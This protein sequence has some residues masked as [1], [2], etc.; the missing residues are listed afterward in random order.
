MEDDPEKNARVEPEETPEDIDRDLVVPVEE[1]PEEYEEEVEA[2]N[3]TEA[4]AD[5]D[6]LADVPAERVDMKPIP[7]P[8][9]STKVSRPPDRYGNNVMM[10]SVSRPIN[11]KLDVVSALMTSGALNSMDSETVS[12]V[13]AAIFKSIYVFL[14]LCLYVA[15]NVLCYDCI[16]DIF[17][18][19]VDAFLG[20]GGSTDQYFFS[21]SCISLSHIFDRF[22]LFL[23]S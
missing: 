10:T 3:L 8:R 20:R 16:Y 1:T 17:F 21:L 4:Y 19:C 15:C 6:V 9:R 5:A 14:L 7:S 18:G 23:L 11:R 2:I 12:K 22:F 13:I